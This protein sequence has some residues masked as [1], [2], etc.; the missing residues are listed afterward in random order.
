M[1]II[2]QGERTSVPEHSLC[3]WVLKGSDKG[4]MIKLATL[5]NQL[6]TIT[7]GNLIEAEFYEGLKNGKY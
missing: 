1:V 6:P 5:C 4:N 7:L 2:P 3:T